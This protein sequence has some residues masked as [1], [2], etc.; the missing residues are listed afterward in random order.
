MAALSSTFDSLFAKHGGRIPV[1]YLRALSFKESG[2]NPN[3][4]ARA[5]CGLLQVVD[6]VVLPGFNARYGTGYTRSSL[7]DPEINI[8]VGADLL[9]RIAQAYARHPDPNMQTDF[10]NPEFVKLL[11]AGWNSGYSEGGG[12]GKVASYL[13]SRGLPVTHD[14]VF[15]HAGAAGATTHLQN[16]AKKSWQASVAALFAA[17]PDAGRMGGGASGDVSFWF[18][19]GIT[20]AASLLAARYIFK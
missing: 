10:S 17:Q 3:S 1:A 5:A 20:A 19:I 11:T 13:E 15:A 8:R 14:N 6:S 12:V 4:C 2:Q 9:N 18:K 16:A 7:L